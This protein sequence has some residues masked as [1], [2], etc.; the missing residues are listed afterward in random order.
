MIDRSEVDTAEFPVLREVEE[1]DR[2]QT[3]PSRVRIDVAA[4]SHKGKV[5]DNNQDHYYVGH[6]GRS[7]ET[8]LTNLPEGKVPEHFDEAGYVLIVADGMGGV[9]GGEMA[10]CLAI[11]TL[12]NIIIH[13][14]DWILRFDDEHAQEVMRRA[15]DYFRQVNAV[16]V[17]RAQSE[18]RLK[19]M[20]T[21]MTAAY[22][23]GDDL[24][25]AHVGD[26]RAYLF[27]DERLQRLTRDQ[28]HAQMLADAGII[29]QDEV[30]NHR[31]RHVLTNSLGGTDEDTKVELQRLKLC[32]GDRL[33]LCTDGLTDMVD[34][35]RITSMLSSNRASDDACL[36][37]VL[38]ALENGGKDNVTVVL[39]RYT[40]PEG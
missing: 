12:I 26:S 39:Q 35:E 5:R 29:R 37:L 15:A 7:I 13:V 23:V 31:L 30:T 18:P 11:Q 6:A 38:E 40:I 21:T 22:S 2:P 24:F 36:A 33:L 17:E 20:G 1:A 9:V 34:E 27:R 14:P 25:V 28:T 3:F 8:L 32:D 10:S 19:G 4:L 16:L